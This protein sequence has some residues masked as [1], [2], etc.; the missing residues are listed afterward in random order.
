MNHQLWSLIALDEAR[1]RAEE[2]S[3]LNRASLDLDWEPAA[4]SH[5]RRALALGL[6]AI[7]RGAAYVVRKLDACMADDLGRSLASTE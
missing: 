3:R 5:P 2:A 1:Q 7:S 6:A 4:P